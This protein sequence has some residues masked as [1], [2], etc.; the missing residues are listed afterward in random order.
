MTVTEAWPVETETKSRAAE[1]TRLDA[2]ALSDSSIFI[3][4]R[5]SRDWHAMSADMKPRTFCL[6]SLRSSFRERIKHALERRSR[7]I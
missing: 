3:V 4:A 7:G 1:S 6:G 5:P 2:A